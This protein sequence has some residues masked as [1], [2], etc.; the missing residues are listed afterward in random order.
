MV[1]SE[2][3]HAVV[4]VKVPAHD[5]KVSVA[6][7]LIE[8]CAAA[9]VEAWGRVKGEDDASFATMDGTFKRELMN[10]AEDIYRN[11]PPLTGDTQRARFE[12]T[13]A[14]IKERQ[15]KEAAVAKSE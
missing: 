6:Y 10:A 1:E 14:G 2:G 8:G 11:S 3:G 15:E 7:S 12:Q 5:Q 9:A 13:V 4:T